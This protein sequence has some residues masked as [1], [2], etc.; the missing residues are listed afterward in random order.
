MPICVCGCFAMSESVQLCAVMAINFFLIWLLS[1]LAKQNRAGKWLQ[2]LLMVQSIFL[3]VTAGAK[4]WLYISR[5]G[6]TPLR[7][8]SLSIMLGIMTRRTLQGAGRTKEDSL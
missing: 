1:I 7:L 5:F 4:L 8:L 6:F 2:G 3:A